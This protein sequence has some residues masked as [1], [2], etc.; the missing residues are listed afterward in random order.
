MLVS[1]SV[2]AACSSTDTPPGLLIVLPFPEIRP[3]DSLSLA[4]VIDRMNDPGNLGTLLRSALAAG[5]DIAY[6]TQGTV[7][8]FNPKVVRGG[9]GAQL[10]LPIEQVATGKLKDRLAGMKTWIAESNQGVPY[11]QVDWTGPVALVVGSEA[12][13]PSPELKGFEIGQ[14]T[15]PHKEQVESLNAAVAGSI[16][17]FEIARQ[18]GA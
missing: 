13:G 15:I 18:R 17:L 6:L 9:M 2:L 1:G 4:L 16:I 7:D 8:P 10:Q 14:V 11:H 3:T 12:H 5:V